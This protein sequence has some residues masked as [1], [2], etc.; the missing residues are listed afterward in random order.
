MKLEAFWD[1]VQR[2][3]PPPV[4]HLPGTLDVVKRLWSHEDGETV[5]LDAETLQLVD[6][7][8]ETKGVARKA[9]KEAKEMEAVLRSKLQEA[10]FGTLED[11]TMLTLKTTQRKGYTV[12]PKSFRTLRRARVKG[13]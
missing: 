11:G 13:K 3:D 12:E 8:E 6:V 9:S 5:V 7:W 2:K 4:D 10:T 1:R